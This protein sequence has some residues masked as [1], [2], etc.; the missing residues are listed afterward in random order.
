MA[1]V[2]ATGA[3]ETERSHMKELGAGGGTI[4]ASTF[5]HTR[6]PKPRPPPT[7]AEPTERPKGSGES[8]TPYF[9]AGNPKQLE[10]TLYSSKVEGNIPA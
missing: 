6:D 4:R 3:L 2:S 5:R 8:Q 9:K 10:R 7:G 1:P